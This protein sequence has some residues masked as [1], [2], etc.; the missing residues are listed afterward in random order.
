MSVLHRVVDELEP[1]G[2]CVAYYKGSPD[3]EFQVD[4]CFMNRTTHVSLLA[5]ESELSENSATKIVD[6]DF[7]KLVY[8][9][10]R[11]RV[12]I[13]KGE[14]RP[15]LQ[16]AEEFLAA[17][18]NHDKNSDEYLF[19]WLNSSLTCTRGWKISFDAA[20]MPAQAVLG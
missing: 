18:N 19:I 1:S 12:L 2:N 4:A 20:G 5:A 10:A 13:F 15:V 7:Q 16:R 3:G 9:R 11:F 8:F 17:Y 14:E 6:D